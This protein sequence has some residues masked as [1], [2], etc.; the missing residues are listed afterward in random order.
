MRIRSS[1][2]SAPT[3]CRPNERKRDTWS[4]EIEG[5]KFLYPVDDAPSIRL[6]DRDKAFR[7]DAIRGGQKPFEKDLTFYGLS[8]HRW[9]ATTDASWLTVEPPASRFAPDGNLEIQVD[10]SS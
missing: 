8:F 1:E 7:F 10:Q 2:A 6:Y 4:P 5:V 9:T 3:S